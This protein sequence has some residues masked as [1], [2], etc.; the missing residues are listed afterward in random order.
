MLFKDV[1]SR[2]LSDGLVS[3]VS[4]AHATASY[5]Q[6]WKEGETFDLGKSAVQVH[7]ARLRKIGIDIK[8]PYIEEVYASSD[9]CRGE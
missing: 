4:A 8:K 6:L 5:F 7:R 1:V 2:L 9:E 3:S